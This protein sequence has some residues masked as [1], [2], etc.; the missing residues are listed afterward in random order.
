LDFGTA[1]GID[2]R[3]YWKAVQGALLDA[4]A[5]MP[6]KD[7]LAT[8]SQLRHFGLLTNQIISQSLSHLK[9]QIS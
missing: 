2:D 8:L 1:F 3:E 6:S 9:E 4:L 5:E 7:Q